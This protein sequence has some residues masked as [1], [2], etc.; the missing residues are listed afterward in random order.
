ML[1]VRNISLEFDR[2]IL[3]NVNFRIERGE[4][5]GIV[6][7]SGEGKSSLLKI[8]SGQLTPQEGELWLEER[9]L[10]KANQLLL[11]EFPH[12]AII[13]QHYQLDPYH[14]VIENIREKVLNLPKIQRDK[15]VNQLLKYFELSHLANTKAHLIS[16]GEQ[17]RLSIARALAP[18][19]KILL[20][21]EP[22]G[23][24]DRQTRNKIG[25]VVRKL[26]QREGMGLVFVSHEQEDILAWCDKVCFLQKG[27]LSPPEKTQKA[28]FDSKNQSA[29]RL[30]GPINVIKSSHKSFYF[31]PNEWEIAHEN[32]IEVSE[33]NCMFLGT[34]YYCE[35]VTFNGEKIVLYSQIPIS[36]NLR[37]EIKKHGN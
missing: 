29:A 18:R 19:P 11:P 32:G 6:G 33:I 26:V 12:I 13:H 16:G 3:K 31:R 10:P 23:H 8:M 27:K 28:Y 15:W 37:I 35:G 24:L 20:L 25:Q 34:H 14:T 30:L 9:I 17:Q 5:I 36:K 1:E 21:D 4:S 2:P 7:K 22:F